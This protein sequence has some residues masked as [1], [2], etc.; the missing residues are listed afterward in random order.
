MMWRYLVGGLAVAAAFVWWRAQ[1]GPVSL[2][3]L[4]ARYGLAASKY[5]VLAGTETHV[6]DEGQ[7]PV[8]VLLHGNGNSVWLWNDWAKALVEAGFRVIRFD[9]PPYGLSARAADGR[10]GVVATHDALVELMDVER[11]DRALL[12]GTANGG[13]P[14][15]WYAYTHPQ[16][17]AALVLINAPFVAPQ[18][19]LTEAASPQRWIRDNVFVHTGR[20][21]WGSRWYAEGLVLAR[22]PLD[23]RFVAHIHDLGRRADAPNPLALYGSSYTFPSDR[24]NA[25]KLSNNQML[26]Q[27]QVPTLIQWGGRAL[28]ATSEAERLASFFSSAPPQ[29]RIYP[30]AGHWLPADGRPAARE[31]V[32]RFLQTHA[33]QFSTGESTTTSR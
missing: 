5:V 30:E 9:M 4:R 1:T 3:E 23:D 15:A 29:V 6:V 2:A 17:V 25:G 19:G 22:G 24:W 11:I 32:V 31:D 18:A 13:P 20:P 21:L 12:V 28:L 16:R 7:G 26:A 10:H 27:L 8:V 33:G 14:A